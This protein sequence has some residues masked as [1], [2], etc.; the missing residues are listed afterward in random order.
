MCIIKCVKIA[1]KPL[2]SAQSASSGR[3]CL[4]AR[5]N[6]PEITN[7]SSARRR[8]SHDTDSW[9][10]PM[11]V[12]AEDMPEEVVPQVVEKVGHLISSS[13]TMASWRCTVRGKRRWQAGKSDHGILPAI[14]N[15]PAKTTRTQ[16]ET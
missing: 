7:Y 13:M 5:H 1:R 10:R 12:V 6:Q 8:G 15:G 3:V 11:I 4:F 9:D 16:F 2:C 14:L